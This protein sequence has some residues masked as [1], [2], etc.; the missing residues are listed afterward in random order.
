M[1]LKKHFLCLFTTSSQNSC[2]W[3]HMAVIWDL[4]ALLPP[5][6]LTK[7][8]DFSLS[9]SKNHIKEWF[10]TLLSTLSCQSFI[11][12]ALTLKK[13]QPFEYRVLKK[14]KFWKSCITSLQQPHTALQG[15]Q[16]L[17]DCAIWFVWPICIIWNHIIIYKKKSQF[18]SWLTDLWGS[19]LRKYT[20]I[21]YKYAW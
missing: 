2:I 1:G 6:C 15:S 11:I 20:I 17:T 16:W 14:F 10:W 7:L 4:P 12:L 5:R 9:K 8:L 19:L 18:H 13:L 21:L 3:V